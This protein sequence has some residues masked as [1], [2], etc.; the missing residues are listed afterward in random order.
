MTERVRWW[1]VVLAAVGLTASV[2]STY[3]HYQLMSD[4]G[5]TSF[6]DVNETVSCTTLYQ[7][8]YGSVAGIPVALGGV[9]WFG[10]VLLLTMADR[11]A[12]DASREHVAGY[13]LVW[14]TIGLSVGMYMAFASLYVLQTF[15]LMCGLVYVAVIGIFLLAGSGASTPVLKLPAAVLQDAARLVKRPTR[16]VAPVAFVITMVVAAVWFPQPQPLAGLAAA[17]AAASSG[18]DSTPARQPLSA[19]DQR[20]EFA[21]YWAELPRVDLE[22]AADTG[23]ALV[24]VHKFNDYQCPACANTHLAYEPVFTKYESSHPGEVRLVMVDFPL[25]STCNDQSPSGPHR[26]AC[27]AAVAARLAME[28]GEDE[29]RRMQRWLYA[30]QPGM[31]PD[32]VAEALADI[33]GVDDTWLT[34]RYDEVVEDVKADIAVGATLPVEATPTFIINGVLLS[35]GLSPEFFDQA[36]ALELERE[37]TQ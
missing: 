33:V 35:S 15:C 26:A 25:D 10:V 21:R 5:Y 32:T 3:M 34:T 8:R 23:G 11:R 37:A 18:S 9:F 12:S 29:G 27:A 20:S 6:C 24:V 16:L 1:V 4:P 17:V 31:T 13:F 19:E 22:V 7:S 28:V 30:N 2:S 36:I 14:S